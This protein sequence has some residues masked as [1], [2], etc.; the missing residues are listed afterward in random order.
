MSLPKHLLKYYTHANALP[1]ENKASQVTVTL[2]RRWRASHSTGPRT[3]PTQ[4]PV[5]RQAPRDAALKADA[6]IQNA[7][8]WRRVLA[9]S[10]IARS[11]LLLLWFS[12]FYRL[13]LKVLPSC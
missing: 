7:A 9:S 10:L 8:H 2:T 4:G 5:G 6:A 12:L 13:G 11:V 1:I 3:A